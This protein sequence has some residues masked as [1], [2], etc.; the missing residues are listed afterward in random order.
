[1]FRTLVLLALSFPFASCVIVDADSHKTSQGRFVGDT[2]L[3]R[4]EP[5]ATQ[6]YVLAVIGEPTTRTNL[7]TGGAVW[8]WEFS[9]KVTRSGHVLFVVRDDS[10]KETRGAAYVEFGEDGLVSA[11]WRD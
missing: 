8:K 1:M 10:T 5:G 2:T 3:S 11:S 7:S 4:I 9:E 6:E